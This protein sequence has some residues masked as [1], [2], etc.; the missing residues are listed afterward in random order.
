MITIQPTETRQNYL[1]RAVI[2][3]MENNPVNDYTVDYDEASCD[4]YCLIEDIR[5]ELDP[6]IPED[7]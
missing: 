2:R 4:G 7:A 6:D 5:A 1:M 3:Y